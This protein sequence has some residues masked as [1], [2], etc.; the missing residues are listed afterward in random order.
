MAKKN[1]RHIFLSLRINVSQGVRPVLLRVVSVYGVEC[2]DDKKNDRIG[3]YF[4][5]KWSG[6]I[7]GA[8]PTFIWAE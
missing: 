4:G 1:R 2:W 5:K 7:R 8:I 6:P 3:K